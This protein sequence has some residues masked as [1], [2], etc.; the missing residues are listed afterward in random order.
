M[1]SQFTGHGLDGTEFLANPFTAWRGLVNENLING[2]VILVFGI[3]EG[4]LFGIGKLNF[5]FEI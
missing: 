1:L 3:L 5:I 4:T 2:R